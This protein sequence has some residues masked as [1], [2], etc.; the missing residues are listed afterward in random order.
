MLVMVSASLRSLDTEVLKPIWAPL[1]LAL[2]DKASA[3]L[4]TLLSLSA[5][6][7]TKALLVAVVEIFTLSNP[8]SVEVYSSVRAAS[9][10]A[11]TPI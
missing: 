1:P 11:P 2:T 7:S 9:P 3:L 5:A 10:S 4:V 8:A 6:T